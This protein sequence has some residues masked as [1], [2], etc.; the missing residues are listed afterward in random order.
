M[1]GLGNVGVFVAKQLRDR[2]VCPD[3]RRCRSPWFTEQP[4]ARSRDEHRLFRRHAVE[5]HPFVRSAVRRQ[6]SIA[7]DSCTGIE[8]LPKSGSAEAVRDACQEASLGA[9]SDTDPCKLEGFLIHEETSS[10]SILLV[11]SMQTTDAPE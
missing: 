10:G 8:E 5:L 6:K 9:A 1:N 11:V 3:S 7:R 4:P 2:F